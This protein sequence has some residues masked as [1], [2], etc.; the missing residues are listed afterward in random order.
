MSNLNQTRDFKQ[1]KCPDCGEVVQ[2]A[3]IGTTSYCPVCGC[4]QSDRTV[5]GGNTFYR[6]RFK[7]MCEVLECGLKMTVYIS[8]IG[9]TRNN[10]TQET[11]RRALVAHFG[12]RLKVTHNPGYCSYDYTYVLDAE[13]EDE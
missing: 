13:D 8:C 2:M 12:D 4:I 9:H 5:N 1:V 3:R 11:Y 6:D 10:M 7:E